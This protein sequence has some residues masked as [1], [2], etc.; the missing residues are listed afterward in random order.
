RKAARKKAGPRRKTAPR[1][2]AAPHQKAARA[3]APR[4][5]PRLERARRTLDENVPPPP[6]SLDMVRRGS[7]VRTGRKG[8]ADRQSERMGM[9]P[10]ITGGD[11]DVDLENA[12]FTGD[13]A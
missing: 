4:K 2:K 9:S 10:S 8:V 3:A 5:T 11:V 1:V 7:A 6:S 12:Y 13:E